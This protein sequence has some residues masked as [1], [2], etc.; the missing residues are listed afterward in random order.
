ME[1][2]VSTVRAFRGM[3]DKE[4]LQEIVFITSHYVN[5]TDWWK[6]DREDYIDKLINFLEENVVHGAIDNNYK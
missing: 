2:G 4:A 3:K 1:R 5:K 6:R